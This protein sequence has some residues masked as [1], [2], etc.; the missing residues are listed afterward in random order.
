MKN[1]VEIQKYY[2]P[3]LAKAALSLGA[4]RLSPEKPFTWASGYHMPIYNDNRQFLAVPAYR[5]L[6]RDAFADMIEAL[7]LADVDN[8]SGTATAGIPHAVT[9]ADKLEKP[10][11]YVRSS[12]KDHGMGNQIEGLAGG[13]F[14]GKRVLLIEDLISTGSSS[15][16]ALEA[17]RRA[18]GVCNICLAIFTYGLDKA[19]EAFGALDPKCDV[20]T[21][22]DYPTM[23][24]TAL[25]DGYISA[26][27]AESLKQ[28]RESPFEWGEKHGFPKEN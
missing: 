18:D 6:I 13:S 4:I 17:I 9:L 1:I 22:L 26:E 3:K 28:W 20:Y 5:M 21:I 19:T 16:K 24:Q 7:G 15:I 27:N 11:S 8:I 23:L 25:A 2:G 14:E 12:A 10:M